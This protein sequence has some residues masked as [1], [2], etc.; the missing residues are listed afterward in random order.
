[1]KLNGLLISIAGLLA[2]IS[3]LCLALALLTLPLAIHTPSKNV[4]TEAIRQQSF[5]VKFQHVL[6]VLGELH[7]SCQS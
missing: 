4:L 6:M 1:M 5:S 2:L 7:I 3:F